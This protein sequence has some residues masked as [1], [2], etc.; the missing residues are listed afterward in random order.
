MPRFGRFL[1][2]VFAFLSLHCNRQPD[3]PAP[4]PATVSVSFPVEREVID[5]DEYTGYL[6]AVETVD[7]RARVGGYVIK[8]DFE[9]G[10]VVE[11]NQVL[12]ELDP[13]P[14]QAELDKATGQVQQAE[15]Q[16]G[17]AASEF[18]RI[19]KLRA[20]GGGSEN[21]YQ[22][23]RFAKL[24]TAAAVVSAKATQKL[25][26]DNL[27]YTKVRTLIR[28]RVS[29][30]YVTAGNLITGG[31]AAGT[32]LT[33]VVKV[34][35]IYCYTDADER[36]VLKYQ[37]LSDERKRASARTEPIPCFMQL[38][39]ESG[40]PHEGYVDFVDNRIDPGTG[41]L[42]ARAVFKNPGGAML[43]GYFARIRV[44]GS[45]RYH[46]LLVPDVAVDTSQNLRFL[47]VVKPDDTVEMR[48]VTLGSTFGSFRVIESGITATDRVVVNGILRA[49][50]GSKVKPE[51]VQPNMS[52]LQP[53][54]PGSPTTQSLP[55]TRNVP[56][57]APAATAPAAPSPAAP[58]PAP[59]TTGG[60]AQ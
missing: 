46:A 53:I 13:A 19:E 59:A 15:A 26:Q 40:F 25:A 11:A 58:A 33:T 39:N 5:W 27:E 44:P 2:V 24:Q 29:R 21:E 41:T 23:A 16:A 12:F 6:D 56:A 54:A 34:D 31:T 55:A 60:D 37:R 18:A 7:L 51:V 28:G 43:P 52:T 17:N 57:T 20:S 30:K 35:P 4:P 22:N 1:A 3:K 49:I 8:A 48:R 50:P 36:N 47:R 38:L 42:R 9:E 14:F 32:L 45:G 10:K